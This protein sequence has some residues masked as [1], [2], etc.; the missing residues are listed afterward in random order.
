MV[1]D[2]PV[3]GPATSPTSR[4]L[5]VALVLEHFDPM[6]GGLESWT[7]RLAR[8][9]VGRGHVVHVVAADFAPGNLPIVAHR[10]ARHT[11]P[12]R[13]AQGVEETVRSLTVDLVHDVGCG[14]SADIFQPQTGSRVLNLQRDLDSMPLVARARMLLSPGFRRWRRDL[15]D[16]ERRQMN[17]AECVIAVSDLVKREIGTRYG[18]SPHR[19]IVVRNGIDTDR[20]SLAVREKYRAAARLELGV[21]DAVMFLAVAHNFRLKGVDAELE[22]LARLPGGGPQ[23]SRL[24]VVGNGPIEEYRRKAQGLGIANRV[25]FLGGVATMER[26]YAAADVFVH[27][28]YHDACSL[29]TLEALATGL[30]AITT[31]ANGAADAMRSGR[32]GLVLDEA[33]DVAALAD[34]MTALLDPDRRETF[35]YA[36][37]R[38]APAL[39][40][41]ANVAGIMNVYEAVLA[42]RAGRAPL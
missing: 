15:D 2:R 10:V 32:E 8:A 6:I 25:S 3:S 12:S 16:C 23:G 34:A 14:W 26:V 5:R 41:D 42:R 19:L 36:A 38:L 9:L 20:F 24:V 37:R 35:G 22:A 7:Y 28:T 40:F 33:G 39:G 30:P 11:S 1:I 27:T 4:P 13:Q 21:G 29:A 31:R 17:S 18:L